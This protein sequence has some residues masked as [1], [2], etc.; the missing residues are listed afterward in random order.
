MPE[1]EEGRPLSKPANHQLIH[2]SE[3][4]EWT[5]IEARRLTDEVKAD[6]QRLWAKLLSLYEGGAHT[7]LGYA[8]WADYCEQE[9]HMRKSHAYRLLQAAQVVHQLARQSP[10]GESLKV[11]SQVPESERLARELVPLLSNP[12]AI[13]EAWNEAVETAGGVPTAETLR[14][15]VARKLPSIP[16][17]KKPLHDLEG[18][19]PHHFKLA[20]RAI[21]LASSFSSFVACATPQDVL[22]GLKDYEK[23]A[24]FADLRVIGDWIDSAEQISEKKDESHLE[25]LK[26][27]RSKT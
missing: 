18:V 3:S 24:F 8:S 15:I 13:D 23:S 10:M 22:R 21:G 20:T 1:P 6:A 4:A 26:C 5:A 11:T 14:E 7:A 17:E 12:Q 27:H 2:S 9:F 25:G 16:T 19:D